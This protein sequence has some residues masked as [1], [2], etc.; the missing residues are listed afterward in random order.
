MQVSGINQPADQCP[1]FLGVPTPVAAPSFIRPDSATDDANREHQKSNGDGSVTEAVELLVGAELNR[2]QLNHTGIS[3]RYGFA[4]T[5]ATDGTAAQFQRFTAIREQHRQRQQR[6]NQQGCVADHDHA[7][8][9]HQPART[10]RGH[11]GS[12]CLQLIGQSKAGKGN[13]AQ[14]HGCGSS[15]NNRGWPAALHQ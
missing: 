13:T 11:Q 4:I 14:T 7:H 10:Q 6:T 5:T 2:L 1:G 12:R 15:R 8:V 9:H 3:C